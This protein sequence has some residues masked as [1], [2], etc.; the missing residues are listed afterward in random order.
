MDENIDW[1][2]YSKIIAS[3]YRIKIFVLLSQK[4][5]SPKQISSKTKIPISHVSRT[6]KE[7]DE[8]NLIKCLTSKEIKRGKIYSISEKGKIYANEINEI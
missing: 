2:L 3:N 1:D 4:N 8:L 5:L 7:L 6:L